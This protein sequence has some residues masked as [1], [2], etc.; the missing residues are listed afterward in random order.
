M[1]ILNQSFFFWCVDSKLWSW[2]LSASSNIQRR[3]S[4]DVPWS[5]HTCSSRSRCRPWCRSLGSLPRPFKQGLVFK[6]YCTNPRGRCSSGNEG[7]CCCEA[8]KLVSNCVSSR[9]NRRHAMVISWF[10]V[11]L[12]FGFIQRF[13]LFLLHFF[14]LQAQLFHEDDER[15]GTR[16]FF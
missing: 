10:F 8:K 13:S 11:P 9:V 7:H 14:Y 1:Q 16:R 15:D 5:V 3:W 12:S 2:Y 4:C 6:L